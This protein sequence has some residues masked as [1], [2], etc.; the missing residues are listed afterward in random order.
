MD[1]DIFERGLAG[2]PALRVDPDQVA[3][4]GAAVLRRR[5]TIAVSMIAASAAVIALGAALV[6]RTANDA[7]ATPDQTSSTSVTVP[8]EIGGPVLQRWE[9]ALADAPLGA[10]IP[11]DS[12]NRIENSV[13][14][15]ASYS[16][17]PGLWGVVSL[18][19]EAGDPPA[20]VDPGGLPTVG[21]LDAIQAAWPPRDS[22]PD[23]GTATLTRPRV[24]TLA[25]LTT[26]G[27]RDV[28]VWRFDVQGSTVTVT[29][30][31]ISPVYLITPYGMPGAESDTTT[32]VQQS[33]DRTVTVAV[34]GSAKECGIEYRPRAEESIRVIELTVEL[35][36]SS[37]NGPCTEQLV[38]HEL[39]VTLD[40][41]VND[42]I[43]VGTDGKAIFVQPPTR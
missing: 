40:K 38:R 2:E 22:N 20:P 43:V 30:I 39:S 16:V 19:L 33:D 7:S 9:Q 15:P 37:T 13:G 35:I 11:V 14:D 23:N 26:T 34:V 31:A 4:R 28:P 18:A 41:P 36:K 32:V 10:L 29:A 1:A 21:A 6:P 42:R 17:P 27:P 12:V 25:L 5:R 3:Q 24:E 8:Y